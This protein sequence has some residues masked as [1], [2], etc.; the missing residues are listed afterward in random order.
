MPFIDAH[1]HVWNQDLE[2]YPLAPEFAPENMAPP[3]F[4]PSELFSHAKASG[5]DR[6]VL[7]QMSFYGFDNSY[8]LDAIARWPDVF[9]GVAV[10]DHAAD[11][12]A[13]VM[14]QLRQKGVRGFRIQPRGAS[15]ADWLSDDAYRRMCGVAGELGMAICP[16][17]D[18]E[19][20]PAVGRAAQA[21]PQ[22]TFVVD[23]LGRIGIGGRIE[24]AQIDDLCALSEHA[25]CL[26]KVSA[27]YALGQKRPP[28]EDLI[29][30]I[31][32]VYQSFGAER[33]MWATDCPFQVG[34]ETYEDS[35]S[36][37]RDRL[38]FLTEADKESILTRTAERVFFLA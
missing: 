1:V 11:D 36:L 31:R 38:E 17:I 33:L 32:Q 4:T 5:V 2:R 20:L 6:I 29:P 28:H 13:D 3:T 24:Q 7:I 19:Y 12:A 26:V 8:M 34:N 27:F 22:T 18:P 37:V 9:G 16:L 25:N 21:F 10:I 14:A 30:M 23:H 15:P 35:I